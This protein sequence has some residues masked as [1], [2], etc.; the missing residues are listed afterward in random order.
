[1]STSTL[2]MCKDYIY[3]AGGMYIYRVGTSTSTTAALLKAM[4]V[5]SCTLG[6][7]DNELIKNELRQQHLNSIFE[8]N[9]I[10]PLH[11]N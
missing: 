1:M 9:Q 4:G 8:L 11:P 2:S 6:G 7:Y 3:I 10:N 5:V